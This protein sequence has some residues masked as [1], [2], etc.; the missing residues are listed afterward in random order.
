MGGKLLDLTQLA[1][2]KTLDKT[3]QC[4]NWEKR[5]LRASQIVYA[6]IDAYCLLE[7][8]DVLC[9]ECERQ[10][11]MIKDV[12]QEVQ[13]GRSPVREPK[14]S[15]SVK[16]FRMICTWELYR[17]VKRLRSCGIDACYNNAQIPT[18]K[19]MKLLKRG[20]IVLTTV[21]QSWSN[22]AQCVRVPVADEKT[23]LLHVLK[24]YGIQVTDAD[25]NTRCRVSLL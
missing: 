6:A 25:I 8:Y 20:Y 18:K 10:N 23:Q 11:I 4:S 1:L 21:E 3:E 15:I 9:S 13:V 2:G 17:L 12:I 22:P 24:K 5:P 14:S 16:D 19:T 7:I